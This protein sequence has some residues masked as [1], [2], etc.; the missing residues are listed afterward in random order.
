MDE[1]LRNDGK[2]IK[3]AAR[4]HFSAD[5]KSDPLI[6]TSCPARKRVLYFSASRRGRY[7]GGRGI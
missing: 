6:K 1:G 4:L 7:T 3:G 2:G 5:T